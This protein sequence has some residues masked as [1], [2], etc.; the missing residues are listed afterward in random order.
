M[1]GEFLVFSLLSWVILGSIPI[2]EPEEPKRER[3]Q[4]LRRRVKAKKG[5]NY[6]TKQADILVNRTSILLLFKKC[7]SEQ[8]IMQ[9]EF[10]V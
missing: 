1:H 8:Q 5:R 3:M 4:S 10:H 9:L 6:Y 2:K 7:I